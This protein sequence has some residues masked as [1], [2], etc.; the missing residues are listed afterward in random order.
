V[1]KEKI[2][3]HKTIFKTYTECEQKHG[4]SAICSLENMFFLHVFLFAYGFV[5]K[6]GITKTSNQIMEKM[7]I[8]L[9]Q[10]RP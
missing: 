3:I 10:A 7:M 9:N 2:N 1:V 8:K 4:Q 6:C 5:R